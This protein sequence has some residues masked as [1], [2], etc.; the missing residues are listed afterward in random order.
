[1]NFD[2]QTQVMADSQEMVASGNQFL[3]FMLDGEEYGVDILRVQEIKGWEPTTAIPNSPHYVLGVINL[4]GMV[5]PV[6]DLRRRFGLDARER[7]NLT[8]VIVLRT[9]SGDKERTVGFVVDGVSDVYNISDGDLKPSPDFGYTGSM[10]FVRGLAQV[11]ENM[12][13][14]LDIDNLVDE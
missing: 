11:G 12:V 14:V 8:V 7:T 10:E 13:I 9:E 5:I 1:M 2:A 3:T 4:R 6:I